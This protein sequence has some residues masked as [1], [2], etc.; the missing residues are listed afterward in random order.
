MND[1]QLINDRKKAM[2]IFNSLMAIDIHTHTKTRE[3]L[4]KELKMLEDQGKLR[5]YYPETG[6][7]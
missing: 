3:E 5:I 7:N 6:R 2:R 4:L 1:A